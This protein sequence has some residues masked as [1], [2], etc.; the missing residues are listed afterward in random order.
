M[1][2]EEAAQLVYTDAFIMPHIKSDATP[3]P[4]QFASM[5][6]ALQPMILGS[7]IP[8]YIKEAP[9]VPA[10]RRYGNSLIPIVT[11]KLP[12]GKQDGRPGM[13]TQLDKIISYYNA[14]GIHDYDW[15]PFEP[16]MRNAVWNYYSF[17][18]AEKQ[19]LSKGGRNRKITYPQ[20]MENWFKPE[21]DAKTAGWKSGHAPFGQNDGKLAPLSSRCTRPD[22]GCGTTP[23]TLWEKEVL[24]MR[25]TFELPE[26]EDDHRYRLVLGG[27]SH[28]FS[29]E[30]YSIY[31][32]GKLF[33]ESVGGHY[34]KGGSR[35]EYIYEDFLP[36]FKKG[37]VT[38][39][40]KGFLRYT[41]RKNKLAPP[42][43]HLSVWL[44]SVKLPEELLALAEKQK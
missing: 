31:V 7:L 25:Q 1:T 9:G 21:F 37:Q 26:L 19:E 29:G 6:K 42:R 11:G 24:L 27:S 2:L 39:A 14:A 35:G 22:C 13:T 10:C 23:K 38:I 8:A 32:N 20:G 34:K 12:T 28:A 17:D 4:E 44:E 5:S 30:G 33:S 40:V 43:G 3:T 18:P 41:G 36:E 15:K 16:D